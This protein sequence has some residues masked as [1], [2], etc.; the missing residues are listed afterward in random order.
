MI[1][2]AIIIPKISP[3]FNQALFNGVK[4]FELSNPK[5]IK[6]KDKSKKYIF[7]L[8]SFKIGYKPISKKTIK[9]NNTD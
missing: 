4:N 6:G 7:G 1:I 2:G 8:P 5:I 3:N 9:K